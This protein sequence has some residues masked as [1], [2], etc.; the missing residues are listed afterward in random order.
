MTE[1]RHAG[2]D[3]SAGV[4]ELNGWFAVSGKNLPFSSI[5]LLQYE[6]LPRDSLAARHQLRC[7]PTA[8]YSLVTCK[9]CTAMNNSVFNHLIATLKLHNNGPSYSNTVIGRLAVDGWAVTFG[10]ARRG[11]GGAAAVPNVTAHQ[12]TASTPTLCYSMW[13]Y[14]AVAEEFTIHGVSGLN[15]RCLFNVRT[16][17]LLSFSMACRTQNCISDVVE[18]YK[19]QKG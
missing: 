2:D 13:D 18:R 10:T 7:R 12:P 15:V 5:V 4:T 3:A 9:A 19:V 17:T 11:L 1:R 16:V 14:K 8:L 6:L